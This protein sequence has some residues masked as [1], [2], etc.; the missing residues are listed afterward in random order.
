[1]P[2]IPT[3]AGDKRIVIVGTLGFNLV[4]GISTIQRTISDMLSQDFARAT[5]ARPVPYTLL[6]AVETVGEAVGVAQAGSLAC[7][8]CKTAGGGFPFDGLDRFL[9]QRDHNT[10]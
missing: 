10:S 9:Q 3:N 8:H 1:M 6:S 2:T 7:F 5:W 4:L